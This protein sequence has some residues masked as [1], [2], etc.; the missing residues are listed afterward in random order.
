MQE[1]LFYSG[2]NTILKGSRF[3]STSSHEVFLSVI[4]CL[5]VRL[6]INAD[7]SYSG[8]I[9]TDFDLAQYDKCPRVRPYEL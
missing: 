9:E 4:R 3:Q 7:F 6:A 8:N 5:V 1:K 2:Q